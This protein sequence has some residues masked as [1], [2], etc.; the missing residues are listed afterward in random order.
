MSLN[1][2]VSDEVMHKVA[3]RMPSTGEVEHRAEMGLGGL[4]KSHLFPFASFL[5]SLTILPPQ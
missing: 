5:S 3:V 4:M 2:S 1:Q